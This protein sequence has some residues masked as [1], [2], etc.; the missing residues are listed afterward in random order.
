MT[1]SLPNYEN[2]VDQDSNLLPRKGSYKSVADIFIGA[3]GDAFRKPGRMT[4]T[5]C[6]MKYVV[7]RRPGARSGHWDESQSPYMVEPQDLLSSRELRA[8]I[9]VGP[10]QSG[11]TEALIINWLAY[12]VIHDPM[13]MIVFNPTQQNARDFAVRRIDRLNANSPE[14]RARLIRSR[15]YDNK[16]SKT[17]KSGMILNLS[18]PTTSEMAGKPVPHIALTDYDRMDDSIGDEGSPFDLAYM[19]TTTFKSFAM[20]VAE[21]SPSRPIEDMRWVPSTPH[22][23]P[24]CKGILSLYNRGDMRRLYWPCPYCAEYF[25]G[26]WEHLK[27]E[28]KENVWDAADTVRMICPHCDEE[29][30]P[31]QRQFMLDYSTWLKGGQY[32][33][34]GRVRGKAPRT[35]I[36]SF[37][38]RGV[39]AGFMTWGELVV[40]FINAQR[41]FDRTGDET[42]LQQFHNND[43]GE[44]YI[45][46]S[47]E[48]ERLPEALQD[49]SEPFEERHVHS[50]VRFLIAAIDVQKN[51]FKIQV[52]GIGPGTPYDITIIDRYDIRKSERIDPEMDGFAWVKPGTYQEDWRLIVKEVMQKTYPLDDGTGR[53]MPIKLTV[54][55]SGGEDGVTTQAYDFY[56]FLR[57]E[58]MAARFHLVK[59]NPTVGAPRTYIDF[60]DSRQRSK[61]AVARGDV[62]VLFLN[63]NMLKDTLNHRLYSEEPGKGMIR[64]PAWLPMWFY[65]ELCVEHRDEKGKWV[66]T[67]GIRNEAWD[68]LYY[69]IGACA[70]SLIRAEQINWI[71]PPNWSDHWASNS[72]IISAVEV[73]KQVA[74]LTKPVRKRIDFAELGRALASDTES[75]DG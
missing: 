26:R 30:W 11:K 31:D 33:K 63:S 6:A 56:R 54:C 12:A 40:K 32:F 36:A 39:A 14:V 66:G 46:K 2:Q 51:M 5:E 61:F 27:Y 34:N 10:S 16:G 59:G 20:T 19:R 28:Q 49:R 7:I 64:F 50:G 8:I 58:G 75:H 47:Q 44:P 71:S 41:Q 62:P 3:G 55:D 57:K 9:F 52:H 48:L 24:P 25:E 73:E 35:R 37:W 70:S 38:L 60:P 68:L 1:L 23:A 17:Y 67:R 53:R 45:A 29:I 18:W 74:A 21:S 13:D 72:L 4:V 22:E 65:K 69:C 15:A 42:A 43:L